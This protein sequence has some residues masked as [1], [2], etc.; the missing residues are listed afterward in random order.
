MAKP[1]ISVILPVYNVE[2][3]IEE[4]LNSIL[5]QTMIDDLEIIMVDDGSTDKSRHIIDSYALDYDNFHAY[6]KQ[7]EGQGIARNYGLNIAS[8]DFIHF[9]DPDDFLP[10]K[11]YETLYGM[12]LK[13]DSDMVIGNSL[14]FARYNVWQD[15]LFKNSFK[16]ICDEIGSSKIENLPQLVWDT[17]IWNKLY[18]R[19]FLMDNNIR[20]LNKKISFQDI[21]FSL[22]SYLLADS[23]SITPEICNYWRLRNDNTS[24][25]QQDRDVKNF[26]N[27][28]EIM[29]ISSELLEK[30]DAYDGIRNQFYLKWINHDLKFF[31]KRFNH[32]PHEHHRQLF[33]DVCELVELIPDEIIENQF[34]YKKAVL[35]MIK[36]RDFDNFLLFAPLENDLYENPEIPSFIDERYHDCFDFDESLKDEELLADLVDFDYDESNIYIEFEASIN[37]LRD[38]KDYVITASLVESDSEYPLEVDALQNPQIKIPLSFIRNRNHSRIKVSYS[39]D[40]FEKES[41]L[42]NR[43]RKSLEFDDFYVDL[44]M[45]VNS[46]LYIDIRHK[47]DNLI[48]I[49]D[50]A[51]D[52]AEFKFQG[53]SRNVIS[54]IHIQNIISFEKL[55]YP[56]Q[57]IDDS[58]RFNFNVAYDDMLNVPVKKWE[59]NCDDCMNSIE[60]S[61]RFEFFDE[62]KKIRFMNSRN[63][64]FIEIEFYDIIEELYECRNMN[65]KLQSELNSLKSEN[66]PHKNTILEFKSSKIVKFADRIKFNK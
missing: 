42:K 26:K 29:R 2:D 55:T 41:F 1:K 52:D 13:Y 8:G 65:K 40:D 33:D 12:A 46:Y 45:G 61:D 19:E 57:Y 43:H 11:A 49:E 32:F 15:I 5:N 39:F 60:L 34:S 25:T 53:I 18:K 28:L 44:D 59:M 37:Y 64:I 3:Y 4:A 38:E 20:F 36:A 16:G 23:I 48:M 30:Y 21:P 14:R 50:V 7:N 31:I 54:E 22:E 27:R 6:H 10:P 17:L 24:V 47:S 66:K 51:L 56:V 63:K 35:R 9:F 58:S 62:S